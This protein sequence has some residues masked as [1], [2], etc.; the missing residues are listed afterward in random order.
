[1]SRPS[2]TA[3]GGASPK[4]RWKAKSAARTSGSAD[5]IEA[6][7]PIEWLLSA[8]SSNPSGSRAFAAAAR[9]AERALFGKDVAGGKF[10]WTG[11]GQ[12]LAHPGTI[13]RRRVPWVVE[14][15][16]GLECPGRNA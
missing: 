4:S 15:A 11:V 9:P 8:F 16:H 2:S 1:M 3:P 10:G 7:S 12:V 13:D 6:A 14:I 5:T